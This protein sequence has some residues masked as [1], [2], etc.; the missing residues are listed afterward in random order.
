MIRTVAVF[1]G[2]R[3]GN[4]PAYARAAVELGAGLPAAGRRLIYG[5]GAHGLMGLL[6][7][8]A[9]AAGGSVT[10]IMPSFLS[11]YGHTTLAQLDLVETMH[12]RKAALFAQADAFVVLPGGIGTLDELIE[13]ITWRS[14]GQHDKPILVCDVA[15][16]SGPAVAAIDA[17]ISNGFSAP[18]LRA[19]FE[20]HAGAAA[21]LERL[22]RLP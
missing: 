11:A 15:G 12:E 6:A 3:V 13:V 17:A 8:A 14:L 7:D 1:C 19:L 16:S 18:E 20:V 10:G 4:D 21:I 9:L 5:G 22:A 2:S